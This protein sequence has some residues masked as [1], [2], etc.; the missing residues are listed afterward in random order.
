[1]YPTPPPVY[2]SDFTKTAKKNRNNKQKQ[3]KKTSIHAGTRIRTRARARIRGIH[4]RGTRVLETG[5]GMKQVGYGFEKKTHLPVPAL[6]VYPPCPC[7]PWAD[8]GF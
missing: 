1:M 6:P 3:Q 7:P 4:A 2:Y 8:A 5:T